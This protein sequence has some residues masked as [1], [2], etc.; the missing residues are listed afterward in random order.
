MDPQRLVR[1]WR[2]RPATARGLCRPPSDRSMVPMNAPASLWSP[3]AV[4]RKNS[5]RV[6]DAWYVACATRELSPKRPLSVQILGIPLALWR[7]ATGSPAAVL[8]RCPHRNVPLSLG[9]VAQGELECRYHGWRFD[10]CGRLTTVP[11]L[12]IVHDVRLDGPGRCA[13]S[14]RC[15]EADG[16]VWVWMSS[17]DPE[18]TPTPSPMRLVQ[19][20]DQRYL[21]VR[22]SIRV[23]ATL[24]STL[25]NILDVPHTAFLHGGL[26]RTAEKKHTIEVIVTRRPDGV[27]AEF[28]GEPR[29]AGI[30]GR[31]LSPSGGE[32]QHWDRFLLPSTAQVEYRIGAENHVI[33]T[34]LCTP[35]SETITVMHSLLSLRTRVPLGPAV[36]LAAPLA[37]RILSQDKEILRAQ[38]GVVDRF[39]GERFSS[40]PID[41]LGPHIL[42]LLK[43]AEQGAVDD[44]IVREERCSIRV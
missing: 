5:V 18:T 40:T 35:V 36:V 28:I 7:T 13:E 9:R 17:R 2:V 4:L 31:V 32:V 12:P 1:V 26:F 14:F 15:V 41:L 10:G 11:G 24:H 29:P 20:D 3:S 39:G 6:V 27:T 19:L 34:T 22:R 33:V 25:E 43:K 42:H 21:H 30:V 44:A 38:T 23:D 16:Y 8:D 37:W